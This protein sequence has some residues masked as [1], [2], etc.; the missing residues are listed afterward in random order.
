M[1]CRD[2]DNPQSKSESSNQETREQE[3]VVK[4]GGTEELPLLQIVEKYLDTPCIDDRR[5]LRVL[6]ALKAIDA[7]ATRAERQKQKDAFCKKLDD[8]FVQ[9]GIEQQDMH[10]LRSQFHK[11]VL[12]RVEPGRHE[13]PASKRHWSLMSL[14]IV[15]PQTGY[16]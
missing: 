5:H 3:A 14:P 10:N 2:D 15:T 11:A 6:T 8:V 9:L 13:C 1:L 4:Y 12:H 16:P 7:G